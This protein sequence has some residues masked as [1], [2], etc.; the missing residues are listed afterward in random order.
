MWLHCNNEQDEGWSS[1]AITFKCGCI[2]TMRH[3]ISILHPLW[4]HTYWYLST[5][6]HAKKSNEFWDGSFSPAMSRPAQS[7]ATWQFKKSAVFF[8][9]TCSGA[10]SF[11]CYLGQQRITCYRSTEHPQLW[12]QRCIHVTTLCIAFIGLQ[13]HWPIIHCNAGTES[14]LNSI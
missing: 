8:R 13:L 11:R 2:A 10:T 4:C 14:Q 3:V 6:S 5:C 1:C 9:P 7:W 12:Q